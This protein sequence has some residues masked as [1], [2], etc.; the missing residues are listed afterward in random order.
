MNE[1]YLIADFLGNA[2]QRLEIW[3]FPSGTV[4]F[5]NHERLAL[6]AEALLLEAALSFA[7][8]SFVPIE[9]KLQGSDLNR[10]RVFQPGIRYWNAEGYSDLNVFIRVSQVDVIFRKMCCARTVFRHQNPAHCLKDIGFAG[11]IRSHQ[12]ADVRQLNNKLSDRPEVL[13]RQCLNFHA[14]SPANLYRW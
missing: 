10:F 1:R 4:S 7:V 2:G 5:L 9:G 12:G 13:Y 8:A 14:G 11:V 3:P 6:D